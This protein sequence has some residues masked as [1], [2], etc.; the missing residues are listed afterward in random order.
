MGNERYA[1]EELARADRAR[2]CAQG[3]ASNSLSSSSM[4]SS[5]L[6]I[7]LSIFRHCLV[8]FGRLCAALESLGWHLFPRA[9]KSHGY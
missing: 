5:I 3:K 1:R 2:A 9:V 8:V 6:M 7:S 4:T